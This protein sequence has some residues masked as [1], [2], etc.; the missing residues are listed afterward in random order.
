MA[1]NQHA[2]EASPPGTMKALTHTKS[3]L[4]STVLRL[5]YNLPI[6]ILTS[7]TDVLVKI[8][9]AG[10]NPAACLVTQ[11]VPMTFRTSPSIPETDFSGTVVSTGKGVPASRELVQGA[12]VFGSVPLGGMVLNGRGALA[13]YVVVPA[14][15]LVL[16]PKGL[17]SEEAAGLPV[18]GITALS[19]IDLARVK[20][21]ERVLVNGASG[22]I[23]C[24]VVQMAKEAVGDEGRVFA[25]CS[26]RNEE[27]VG[28]L[29]ADEVFPPFSSR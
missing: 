22:G 7:P 12:K 2:S 16:M 3:G 27:L 29:G 10:L 11:I 4:P 15:N 8:S 6:P 17:A 9:H 23:G 1:S 21:G 20:R 24:L 5:S 14:E 26:G 18:P 13:E 19:V 25:I 28:G